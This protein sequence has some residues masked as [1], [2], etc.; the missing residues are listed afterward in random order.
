MLKYQFGEDIQSEETVD[1]LTSV[2]EHIE[3]LSAVIN[4]FQNTTE[5]K[6]SKVE[7]SSKIIIK[8]SIESSS[9]QINQLQFEDTTTQSFTTYQNS[10]SQSIA[11]MLNNAYEAI[12]KSDNKDSKISIKTYQNTNNTIFEISNVGNHI[13]DDIIHNIF[14]PYFSTKEIRNGVGLSLYNC[15][16]IIELHLKGHIEVFNIQKD[17]TNKYETVMF[18]ITLPLKY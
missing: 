8:K 5:I 12:E 10:L 16:T 17:E 1:Y 13:P 2:T 11:H 6:E 15:K 7:T 14:T 3:E 4:N 18:R 9:I